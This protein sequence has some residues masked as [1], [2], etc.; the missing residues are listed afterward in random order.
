MSG[1]VLREAAAQI[2]GDWPVAE[3]AP[4]SAM[5]EETA[6]HLAV[7]DWLDDTAVWA[8]RPESQLSTTVQR[9]EVVARAYI[10]TTP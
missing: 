7:A 8:N 3:D 4:P 5:S 9:A 2:R 10:G 6:F 1:E